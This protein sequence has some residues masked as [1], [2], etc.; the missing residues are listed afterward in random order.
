MIA[1][2]DIIAEELATPEGRDLKERLL[3]AMFMMERYRG[4]DDGWRDVVAEVRDADIRPRAIDKLA[5]T[6]RRFVLSHKEHPDVGSAIWAL[7]VLRDDD[8]ADL[9]DAVLRPDSGYGSHARE[10]AQ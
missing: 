10:Q 4:I 3:Q 1:L 6:L 2:G 5:E 7:G 9:F 8:D